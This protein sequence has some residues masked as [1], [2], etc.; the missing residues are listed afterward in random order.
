MKVMLVR[1]PYFAC[2]MVIQAVY[3]LLWAR[4]GNL[5]MAIGSIAVFVCMC[6]IYLSAVTISTGGRG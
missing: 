3:A 2:W 4:E 5:V 1:R 6:M